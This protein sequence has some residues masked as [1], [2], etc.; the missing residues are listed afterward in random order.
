MGGMS[1]RDR[2][3][4]ADQRTRS[5]SASMLLKVADKNRPQQL[6]APVHREFFV[7]PV[8]G[9]IRHAHRLE[10]KFLVIRHDRK[11]FVKTIAAR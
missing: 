2:W 6:G 3:P 8:P 11:P 9:P 4:R 1:Q 10:V 5:H 7:G